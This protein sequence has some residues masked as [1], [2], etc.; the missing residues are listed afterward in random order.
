MY[1]LDSANTPVTGCRTTKDMLLA[2]LLFD[3]FLLLINGLSKR[4]LVY[5]VQMDEIQIL[6]VNKI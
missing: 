4:K 2:I 6:L 5:L 1:K 3:L